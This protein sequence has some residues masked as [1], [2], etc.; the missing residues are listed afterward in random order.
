MRPAGIVG[1]LLIVAGAIVLALRGVSYVKDRDHVDLGIT[2]V[3]ID[4]HGF[5]PPVAGIIAIA[6]GAVLLLSSR[7]RQA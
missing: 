7:G 2:K 6:I 5:I 3:T 1:L 4:K